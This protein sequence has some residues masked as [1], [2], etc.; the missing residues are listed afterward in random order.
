MRGSEL[1]R[2]EVLLSVL[3]ALPM[4]L[5]RAAEKYFSAFKLIQGI[6]PAQDF[7]WEPHREVPPPHTAILHLETQNLNPPSHLATLLDGGFATEDLAVCHRTTD[8]V[9]ILR[10]QGHTVAHLGWSR[11]L[12][13][14][15]EGFGFG[16]GFAYQR[17]V[18][19]LQT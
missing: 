7:R 1:F 3:E 18:T 17:R 13:V 16:A 9:R 19:G 14:Q 10:G 8:V 11:N 2:L 12:A 6:A 4:I 15:G 5:L